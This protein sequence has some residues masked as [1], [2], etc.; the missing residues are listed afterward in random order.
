M[1]LTVGLEISFEPKMKILS[2]D[3]LQ[4]Q[5]YELLERVEQGESF[6]VYK[7]GKPFAKLQPHADSA[8]PISEQSLLRL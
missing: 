6:V 7:G 2:I 1:V 5:F 8:E 3:E 4:D